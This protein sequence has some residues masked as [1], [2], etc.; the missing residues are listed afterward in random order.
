VEAQVAVK[1]GVI[2]TSLEAGDFLGDVK[3]TA[4]RT[5]KEFDKAQAQSTKSAER[6]AIKQTKIAERE[7]LKQLKIAERTARESARAQRFAAVEAARAQRSA[8]KQSEAAWRNS[9]GKKTLEGGLGG[10]RRGIGGI[11]QSLRGAAGMVAGI[12]GGLTAVSMVGDAINLQ[13]T[14]RD[15]AYIINKLP[16]QTATW[17]D[18]MKQVQAASD[19]TGAKSDDLAAS[20]ATILKATGD[21]A[22]ASDAISAI[23]TAATASGRNVGELSEMAVLLKEKWQ[24]SG[25]GMEEGVARFMEKV[26]AGGAGIEDLSGRFGLFASE[27]IEAGMGGSEGISQILGLMSQLGDRMDASL[28]TQ[29]LKA[30]FQFMKD[31]ASGLGRLEKAGGIKF[32]AGSSAF[33]KMKDVFKSPKAIKEAQKMFTKENRVIFDQLAKPYIE[34]YKQA[35]AEKKTEAEARQMALD[36]FQA[37]IDSLSGST[38]NFAD[39]QNKASKR[40]QDDPSKKMDM[41]LE[42]LRRA[43]ISPQ[44]LGAI[45]KLASKLPYLAEKFG[46]L[47]EWITKNPWKAAAAAGIGSIGGDVFGGMA[48]AGMTAGLKWMMDKLA[49][50]AAGVAGSAGVAAATGSAGAASATGA[51]ATTAAGVGVAAGIAAVAAA[52]AAG[53]IIGTIA[54]HAILNPQAEKAFSGHEQASNAVSMATTASQRGSTIDQRTKALQAIRAAREN[55]PNT[56]K[57]FETFA[58][59]VGS[60]LGVTE[61]PLE[62]VKRSAAALNAA[63]AK[64]LQAAPTDEMRDRMARFSEAIER[65]TKSVSGMAADPGTAPLAATPRGAKKL[66]SQ[67]GAEPTRG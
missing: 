58:G 47:I 33:D 22:F 41:A 59:F 35:I 50:A 1:E 31:G 45:D 8:A 3:K 32:K 7:A 29:K 57:S 67:P 56:M 14:Y 43:F 11:A 40:L 6:E 42:R 23:G 21:A 10:L 44:M 15:I 2:R 25:K 60:K 61:S 5:Q 18:V 48:G 27:A 13:K 46:E 66:A 28:Q 24:L 19:K 52:A 4:A 55:L 12:G 26:D 38:A 64:L 16:G 9:L 34:T 49:P 17:A 54:H 20:Y 36:K 51:A 62:N 30:F 53:G 63:E 37:N 39:L 65:A